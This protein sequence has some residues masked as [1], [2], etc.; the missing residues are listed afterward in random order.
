[1]IKL[2][3]IAQISIATAAILMPVLALAQLPLPANPVAAST[4][5]SLLEIEADINRIA[6]FLITISVVVAVIFIIW[7]GI[8]YAMAGE[9]ATKATSAKATIMNGVIGALVIMAVG[10]IMQTLSDVIARTFFT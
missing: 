4:G 1:M 2:K 9:D 10:V 8:K 6:L 5:L 7:G 3:K